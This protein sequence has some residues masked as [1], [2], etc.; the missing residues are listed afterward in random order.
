MMDAEEIAPF[1]TA[2]MRKGLPTMD[3]NLKEI[4]EEIRKRATVACKESRGTD[5]EQIVC[6]ISKEIQN[7]ISNDERKYIEILE[8]VVS[9]LKI[10]IPSIPE[11]RFIFSKIEAIETQKVSPEKYHNLPL[12]VLQ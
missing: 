3:R 1:A 11:N 7:T 2:A 10:K 5:T 4:I 9:I 12:I 6:E 8:D